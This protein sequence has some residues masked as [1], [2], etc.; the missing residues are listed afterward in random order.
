MSKNA[1]ILHGTDAT[2]GHNW[3]VWLKIELE[4]LGYEVWLPQLPH[5]DRPSTKVYN[6]FLLSNNDFK[7]GEETIII[8]HSSGAVEVLSI[9]ENL[10]SKVQAVFLV[11]AFKDW[12]GWESLN[13]LF[14]PKLNFGNIKG[15]AD[16]IIFIHSDNDP[17]CPLSHPTYLA[18][19]VD[20]KLV[21][22][23]G[24]GHF[25]TEVS[26]KYKRFPELL[27]IIQKYTS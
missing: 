22:M 13:D 25:N 4:Q 24:Q 3:F 9:L 23:Q 21:V 6:E 16:E 1:L 19:Q 12:L 8:G 17:Y 10:D 5:S 11:S 15:K 20:G 26:N 18:E 7:F 14:V 27:D 2:P